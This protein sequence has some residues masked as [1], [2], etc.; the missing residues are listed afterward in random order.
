MLLRLIENP[1]VILLLIHVL[2]Y[3]KGKQSRWNEVPISDSYVHCLQ[4]IYGC[5]NVKS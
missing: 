4:N 2:D 3:Y 5:F 1:R